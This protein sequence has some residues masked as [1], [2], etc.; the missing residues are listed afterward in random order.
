MAAAL[1]LSGSAVGAT[2]PA[3]GGTVPAGH[4]AA[5]PCGGSRAP[6]TFRHV[7]WIL[8]ENHNTDQIAGHSPY[9]NR[10]AARCGLATSVLPVPRMGSL[11]DGA[12][13]IGPKPQ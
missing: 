12:V 4:A 13:T 9:L 10:L 7:V 11:A 8:L 5:R 2:F 3:Y 6:R 1:L